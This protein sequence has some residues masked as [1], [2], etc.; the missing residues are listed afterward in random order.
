MTLRWRTAGVLFWSREA[1]EKREK[2]YTD[3]ATGYLVFSAYG[4]QE[5]GWCCGRGCRH[6]PYDHEKVPIGDRPAKIKMPAVLHLPPQGLMPTAF[7]G[8]DSR[9][10]TLLEFGVNDRD[11]AAVAQLAANEPSDLALIVAFDAVTRRTMSG[12]YALAEVVEAAAQLGRG[13]VGVPVQS[14]ATRKTLAADTV[15]CVKRELARTAVAAN[16]RHPSISGVRIV[17]PPDG[18]FAVVA[19][20]VVP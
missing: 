3:P 20:E 15:A 18:Y 13:L 17:A 12:R 1:C 11:L 8:G 19:A 9:E 10:L 14:W 2:F 5:R 6:C 16:E 4:A 7:P